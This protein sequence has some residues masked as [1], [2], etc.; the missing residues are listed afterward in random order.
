M[1]KIAIIGGGVVGSTAAYYLSKHGEQVTLYDDGNGQATKAAVGIICPWVSQRRNKEWY[2]LAREGAAFYQTLNNDLEDTSY[3]RQSGALIAHDKLLDKLYHIALERREEAPEMGDV[4]ILEGDKLK[5]KIPPF[6]KCNRALYVSGGAQVD[7]AKL[8]QTLQKEAQNLNVVHKRVQWSRQED[9]LMVDGKRY[10]AVI[11]A[12]GAWLQEQ[13][14]DKTVD[15]KPQK[16]QLIEFYDALDADHTYPVF[17]PQGEIDFLYGNQGQ[18]V[19]G[20]THENEQGFNLDV[21]PISS[22]YLIDEAIKYY[23]ELKDMEIN[24]IRVGTRAVSS[25]FS[26]FYG[27]VEGE[28]NLYQASG[29][30]SSGL[31]TGVIIGKKLS[32]KLIENDKIN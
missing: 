16:G 12:C 26:P 28:P 17:M 5:E 15:V 14:P 31:T 24:N 22:E 11:L 7:G 19:V 8:V 30:G 2:A 27:E 29:L 6:I 21:D 3:Y 13:F 20:A 9:Q 23:P 25:N 32:Q 18:L 1:K 10:D 4:I